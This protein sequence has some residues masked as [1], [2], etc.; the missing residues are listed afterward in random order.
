MVSLGYGMCSGVPTTGLV[1][2]AGIQMQLK[3]ILFW[4]AFKWRVAAITILLFQLPC[5]FCSFLSIL[6]FQFLEIILFI[7]NQILE[8]INHFIMILI[9]S[10]L[11]VAF[12]TEGQDR[13]NAKNKSIS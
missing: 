7:G 8:I 13:S 12:G 4:H 1:L 6:S 2:S 3:T 5:C 11:W 10:S 9:I